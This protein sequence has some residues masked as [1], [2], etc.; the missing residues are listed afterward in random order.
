MNSYKASRILELG[1]YILG[2][3]SF[4]IYITAIFQY[5]F[6]SE[7]PL[8]LVLGGIRTHNLLIF[9]LTTKPYCLGA[10]QEEWLTQAFDL[11][12]KVDCLDLSQGSQNN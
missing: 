8:C 1:F 3:C 6:Q 4:A 11:E 2:I 9:V 12:G 5:F 10:R 7:T